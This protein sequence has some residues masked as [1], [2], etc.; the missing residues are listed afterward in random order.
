MRLHD[1]AHVRT[2]DK[3]DISQ[4]SVIAYRAADYPRIARA[5]DTARVG[6]VLGVAAGAIRR[7]ELPQLGALNF[8]LEGALSGGVTR[9]LAL[10]AHGKTLG[11]HLLALEIGDGV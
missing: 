2:G 8:V 6:A 9:S 3:G 5:L 4:I 7:Y 10:D 11:A 1:L